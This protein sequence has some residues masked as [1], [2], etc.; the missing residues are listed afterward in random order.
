MKLEIKPA[1][2]LIKSFRQIKSETLY[3]AVKEGEEEIF[4]IRICNGKFTDETCY[5]LFP[6]FSIVSIEF[7]KEIEFEIFEIEGEFSLCVDQS[8]LRLPF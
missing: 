7:F 8:I 6:H 4:F 5:C 3:K 1:I 2:N